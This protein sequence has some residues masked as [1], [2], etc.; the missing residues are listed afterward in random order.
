MHHYDYDNDSD[1]NNGD[2]DDHEKF[3][4]DDDID[5]LLIGEI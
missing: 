1:E 3:A 2:N 5:F 4:V